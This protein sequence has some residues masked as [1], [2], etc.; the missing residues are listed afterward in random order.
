MR[1]VSLCHV[2][3]CTYMYDVLVGTTN[4]GAILIKEIMYTY[5]HIIYT[6]IQT[7]THTHIHTQTNTN[8]DYRWPHKSVAGM[9]TNHTYTYTYTYTHTYKYKLQ[10][11]PQVRS[12]HGQA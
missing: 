7:H 4:R 6:Y 3:M 8:S 2:F 5:I 1:L 11:A 9:I 10:V 12:R